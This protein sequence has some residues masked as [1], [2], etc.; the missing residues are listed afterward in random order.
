MPNHDAETFDG[1][2]DVTDAA[3]EQ[4]LMSRFA[5]VLAGSASEDE[6][7]EVDQAFSAYVRKVLPEAMARQASGTATTFGLA[8]GDSS[9]PVKAVT[10]ERGESGRED[11]LSVRI[12]EMS[13]RIGNILTFCGI[14]VAIGGIIVA[15]LTAFGIY[16][17]T[18]VDTRIDKA[19]TN[20]DE[21]GRHSFAS[22][23]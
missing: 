11:V 15:I 3:R 4:A 22:A 7:A 1:H 16:S 20:L 14:V 18:V 2:L 5:K 10:G 13:N 12:Q 19:E 17:F 23:K 6:A 21:V 8:A 9:T